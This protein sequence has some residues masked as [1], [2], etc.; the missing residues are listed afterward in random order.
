MMSSIK[1]NNTLSELY[2]IFYSRSTRIV[3]LQVYLFLLCHLF[4]SIYL[5]QVHSL[6]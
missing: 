6:V 3:L 1:I 4:Q 5:L 2:K